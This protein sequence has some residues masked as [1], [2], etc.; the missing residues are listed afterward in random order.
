MFNPQ[1]ENGRR[2]MAT[3][4]TSPSAPPMAFQL[5]TET[6]RT[7]SRSVS[8]RRWTFCRRF[9]SRRLLPR[10][11][12]W[13]RWWA[14]WRWRVQGFPRL[15]ISICSIPS[16]GTVLRK[17][18]RRNLS[19]RA[20]MECSW[21]ILRR[22]SPERRRFGSFRAAMREFFC[23]NLLLLSISSRGSLRY[24]L[25]FSLRLW[26]SSKISIWFWK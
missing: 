9:F 25:C 21:L 19:F 12:T 22:F 1:I 18:R 6:F 4:K 11:W 26:L 7:F 20:D 5:S 16:S 24:A 15:T 3:Y 8:R 17:L 23:L 2:P 13:W 10:S 14:R